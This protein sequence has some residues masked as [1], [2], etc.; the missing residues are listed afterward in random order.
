M[1]TLVKVKI[2][3]KCL[4]LVFSLLLDAPLVCTLLPVYDTL[5]L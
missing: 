1:N 3:K 2:N 5:L 4:M